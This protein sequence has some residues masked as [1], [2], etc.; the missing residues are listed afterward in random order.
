MST[1]LLSLND[2]CMEY[3][4]F[5]AVSNLSIDI[6]AG[7]FISLMGP[8]GC[9]KS[10]TLRMIAGLDSPTSGSML[11]EGTSQLDVPIEDRGMPMV[12]QNFALFPFLNVQKN[13]EFPLRMKGVASDIRAKKASE[14]IERLG[15]SE[16]AER[17]IAQL[18]GGQRQRV[19]L[20]RALVTE[21]R[22]LL[23]D[24]PLS[25]LDAHL[26][27]KMQTELTRLHKELGITFIYVTHSQSEAFAM[28]DRVVIMNKGEIQQVGTPKE[29][30]RAPENAFV[31][32]F[33]GMNN[34]L[35]G[36]LVES[37]GDTVD[38]VTDLGLFK[39]KPAMGLK[40]GDSA[41]M[42]IA[43]DCIRLDNQG[44]Q[45]VRGR[46]SGEEFVGSVITLLV[47]LENGQ[48]FKVQ[49]QQHEVE[50]LN[51]KY[52]AD[53]TLSWDAQSAFLLAA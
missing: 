47:E 35:P 17:S 43:A 27:I 41:H 37:N 32:E 18:S 1:S 20:A 53:L 8:S 33:I 13:V 48:E 12:W 45:K 50:A 2:I 30:Y 19:A 25:A 51:L 46:I 22:V 23:L 44:K 40:N 10:T 24:E 14:W 7:E 16:F 34:L 9:G 4:G 29:V 11:L 38:V 15:L 28:A 52:G 49:K 42:V 26:R 31:A 21:P 3:P 5:K 6:K 39:A 36:T